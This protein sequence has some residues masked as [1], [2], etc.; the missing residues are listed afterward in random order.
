MTP[1]QHTNPTPLLSPGQH[2]ALSHYPTLLLEL[3]Q[4]DRDA[5][6]TILSKEGGYL[7]PLVTLKLEPLSRLFIVH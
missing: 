1:M 6:Y 4:L 3:M 5:R 7:G 2:N